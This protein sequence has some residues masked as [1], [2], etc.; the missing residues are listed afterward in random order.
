M[1]AVGRVGD[2]GAAKSV[3][4]TKRRLPIPLGCL[5]LLKR[6]YRQGKEAKAVGVKCAVSATVVAVCGALGFLHNTTARGWC[7]L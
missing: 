6:R 4:V 1:V 2:G 3:S 5:S 7:V